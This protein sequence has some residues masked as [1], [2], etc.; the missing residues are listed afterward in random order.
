MAPLWTSDETA[1][2]LR[3][4]PVTLRKWRHTRRSDQPP[5]VKV[6]AAV[7]YRS[8]EVEKWARGR[9]TRPE[10]QNNRGPE[11]RERRP[12]PRRS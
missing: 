2:R 4:H 6:G 9:E 10:A 1:F 7:R 8:D 11:R 12:E 5:Y 3:L